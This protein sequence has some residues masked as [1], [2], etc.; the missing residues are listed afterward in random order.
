MRR[1][2]QIAGLQQ[3]GGHQMDRRHPAAGHHRTGTA[4][5]FRQRTLDHVTRRVT[6]ARV[7]MSARLI[8]VGKIIGA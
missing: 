7:V 6:A 3:Y 4:F 1:H 5:Q 8:E 2:Q